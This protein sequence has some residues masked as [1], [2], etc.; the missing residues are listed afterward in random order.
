MKETGPEKS[1]SPALE[2]NL[3][4]GLLLTISIKDFQE[5]QRGLRG[6]EYSSACVL[7]FRALRNEEGIRSLQ[8][9][10]LS[11]VH[12]EEAWN[13]TTKEN[14]IE[15]IFSGLVGYYRRFRGLPGNNPVLQDSLFPSRA[16]CAKLF[17]ELLEQF[18]GAKFISHQLDIDFPSER[19]LVEI[20]PGVKRCWARI[21]SEPSFAYWKSCQFTRETDRKSGGL[22]KTVASFLISGRGCR[23]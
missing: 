20:N 15:A 10:G 11:I 22:G 19:L 1:I 4:G 5:L 18:P 16:T 9:S 14:L 6:S 3:A 12:L 2:Y 17:K 7:P 23:H 8:D 13:P 21:R